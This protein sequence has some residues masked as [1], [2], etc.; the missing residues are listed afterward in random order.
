MP[1]E[2]NIQSLQAEVSHL[3][4]ERDA[5]IRNVADENLAKEAAWA[6]EANLNANLKLCE[7]QQATAKPTAYPLIKAIAAVIGGGAARRLCDALA[8][9]AIE[10]CKE[11]EDLLAKCASYKKES[12]QKWTDMHFTIC[13]L[14]R[15]LHAKDDATA[16]VPERSNYVLGFLFRGDRGSVVLIRNLKP[17]W[18]AGLLNG[19]GGKVEPG[20]NPK[21]AM[22][23]EFME[24]CGVY[25]AGPNWRHFAR[26]S[27][28][29]FSVD[30]YTF[31]DTDAWEKA[32]T[33]ESERIEKIHP[34]DV[35]QS[36]CISNL[37]WLIALALDEN[38]GRHHFAEVR[39]PKEA[40]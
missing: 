14:E 18:Q 26:M 4:V 30:C 34:D 33:Q 17:K 16:P 21:D 20:E 29:H 15:Q 11:L 36:D 31:C 35:K 19:V 25:I 32:V 39:Y 24:E 28:D 27:G 23:R 3:K 9:P 12:E 5:L 38:E 22:N 6:R 1:G 10:R 7:E 13:E 2:Q 8:Y 40:K 37:P